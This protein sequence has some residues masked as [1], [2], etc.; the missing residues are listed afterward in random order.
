MQR[1]LKGFLSLG[2]AIVMCFG[3]TTITHY[4]STETVSVEAAVTADNYYDDVTATSGTQLLGQLHDLITSTHKK[5]TSYS[6]CETYATTTDPGLDGRGVLEFYTH[7]TMTTSLASK[8]G[9]WNREHVWPKSLSNSLWGTTGGGSD[10]H[11][12]RPTEMTLNS[13]RGN[14]KY[15]EVSTRTEVYSKNTSGNNSKLGGYSSGG[16]FEPLNHTKG[17]AARII[18]YVYT[19]YNKAGNVGGKTNGT[20]SGSYFGSL[21]FTNIISASNTDAAIKLLLKWHKEDPVDPTETLRNEQV[22]KIQGNRNPFIDHPEYADA[23]WGGG[24]VTP[25]PGGN[26]GGNTSNTL[27]GISLNK[28][29][30]S[31]NVGGTETLTV[32]PIPST[33]SASVTWSTS[34]SNVASVENGLVTAKAA[35]TAT[36]TATSTVN[37]SIKDSATIIVTGQT[38][39]GGQ[40][41]GSTTQSQTVTIT[42]DS[43]S[44]LGSG[45]YGYYSWSEGA[46]S[47]TAFIYGSETRKMQ[48]NTGKTAKYLASSG[49]PAPA[50]IREITIK[51][52]SET[53]TESGNNKSWRLL[54]S[55]TPYSGEIAGVPTDGYNQGT[56]SPTKGDT[57]WSEE[58]WTVTGDYT[59]FALCYEGSGACYVESITVKYG[60]SSSGPGGESGGGG[61]GDVNDLTRLNAFHSAVVGIP[62]SGSFAS[63]L[64]Y[65][66]IAISIYK[67]LTSAERTLGSADVQLLEAK[68]ASYN[69]AVGAY[70]S[71]ADDI[72]KLLYGG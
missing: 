34:D 10:L 5:Y 11:H 23:I 17:D 36:I 30:V 13:K 65:L 25:G 40:G 28:G 20:G 39:G 24:T 67:A 53:S 47:G 43:F 58:T 45:T 32:T 6:E 50:P 64:N 29:Y 54:T 4:A 7:E 14:D 9:Y 70:N 31:L 60:S 72:N 42:A 44:G 15:G 55:N 68:I 57:G 3:I 33:A 16:V 63:R 22:F 37:T 41:S 18:M 69:Q 26:T 12:I 66:N 56:V 49:N 59:Y 8:Q 71:A 46:L 21:A 51:L 62:S 27:T 2:L 35:G 48:F 1:V 38:Q 52:D 61:T 19:H